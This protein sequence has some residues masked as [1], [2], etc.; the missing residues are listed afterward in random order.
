VDDTPTDAFPSV[1][2]AEARSAG[3]R[4]AQPDPGPSQ[5]RGTSD[6]HGASDGHGHGHGAA[7]PAGRRARMLLAASLA[8]AALAALV[9]LVLL[10]PSGRAPTAQAATAV[11]VHAQVVD[12]HAAR[13][14]DASA[15]PGGPGVPNGAG[16]G[17]QAATGGPVCSPSPCWRWAGGG[18]S[19]RWLRS[20]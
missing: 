18:G 17:P 7:L 12:T 19:R 13:C 2:V 16:G 20:A 5:R 10:W 9:G 1:A 6:R 14:D 11:P 3:S 15:V 8:P 4:T